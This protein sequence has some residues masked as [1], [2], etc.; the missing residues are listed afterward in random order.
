MRHARL[1]FSCLLLPAVAIVAPELVASRTLSRASRQA[2][3]SKAASV[4]D[5]RVKDHAAVLPPNNR[6]GDP[7]S[8][9]RRDPFEPLISDAPKQGREVIRP[10][11]KAGL[12]IGEI[13]V[14]GTVTGPNGAVAVVSSPEGHVYFLRP[15]DHLFDGTV[16][17][18]ELNGVV[19]TEHARDAFGR[20]LDRRVTKAVQQPEGAKP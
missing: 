19:F 12:M 18:V 15:G 10:P 5:A 13:V 2:R 7:L 4:R 8:A 9:R 11:G 14:Q 1:M 3:T 6:R 20:T 16:E 17:R